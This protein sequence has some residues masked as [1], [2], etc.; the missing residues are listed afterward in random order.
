MVNTLVLLPGMDGTGELFEPFVQAMGSGYKILCMRYPG[1][2]AM[3]YDELEKFVRKRLPKKSSYVVLG[4]SFSGPI[5]A[6]LAGSPPRGL[7]GV[8]L[9]CTFVKN[10]RPRLSAPRWLLDRVPAKTVPVLAMAG[11]MMG[12]YSTSNLRVALGRA[13]AQ[14]SDATLKSRML[15]VQSVDATQSLAVAKVPV[16]YLQAAQDYV[17]PKGAAAEVLAHLP[18][19]TVVSINGPHFLLQTCPIA[20]AAEVARFTGSV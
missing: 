20:A 11:V 1:D 3:G 19:T 5:A 10:P 15:A 7:A 8:I 16:L 17:V 6:R 2:M 9:C 14:V 18:S 13:L 4:E 12:R